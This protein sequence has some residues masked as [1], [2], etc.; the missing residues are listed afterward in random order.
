MVRLGFVIRR[1]T[2]AGDAWF[3]QLN[4]SINRPQIK[5]SSTVLVERVS[6]DVLWLTESAR[7]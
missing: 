6:Q 1:G 5:G 2:I 4:Q 3:P 7:G